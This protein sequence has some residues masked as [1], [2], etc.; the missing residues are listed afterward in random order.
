[1][2][3]GVAPKTEEALRRQLEGAKRGGRRTAEIRRAARAEK[4]M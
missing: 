3:G 2:H 1:M 4:E